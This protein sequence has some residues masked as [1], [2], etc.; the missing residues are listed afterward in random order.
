MAM[1][2]LIC[3]DVSRDNTRARVAATLQQV[4]DRIQRSVF[5][6]TIEPDHLDELTTRLRGL[7]DPDTDAIHVVPL[8][9]A[10]WDRTIVVGQATMQ[11]EI[12]YWAVM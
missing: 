10:C 3:Y 2:M 7:V 1:T 12:L 9:A 8:C 11:P 5:V 6:C 4:G